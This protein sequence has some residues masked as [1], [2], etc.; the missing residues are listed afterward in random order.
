MA[1][2]RVSVQEKGEGRYEIVVAGE[3]TAET[4]GQFSEE[5][6]Q[7][8]EQK[9]RCMELDLGRVSYVASPGLG[10]L[11]S[12]LRKVRQLRGEL[13]VRSMSPEVKEIFTVTHLDRIFA[14]VDSTP[15]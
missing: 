4:A 2:L 14:Q 12:L 3:M 8:L 9:P 11:V 7:V 13:L 15:C 6:L 10:A 5:V 1:D